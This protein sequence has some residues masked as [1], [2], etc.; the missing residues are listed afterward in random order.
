MRE[1]GLA[2]VE[3]HRERQL[4]I[5]SEKVLKFNLL[6]KKI[7]GMMLLFG[8]VDSTILARWEGLCLLT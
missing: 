7:L 6:V 4:S 5:T 8:S 2:V 1:E 3:S